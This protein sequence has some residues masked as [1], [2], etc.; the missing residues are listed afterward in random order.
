MPKNKADGAQKPRPPCPRGWRSA[1]PQERGAA[2]PQGKARQRGTERR[3]GR[4]SGAATAARQ[5]SGEREMGRDG[6][7]DGAAL[8]VR[9]RAET[10]GW[11]NPRT[12]S[13]RWRGCDRERGTATGEQGISYR[14]TWII[15]KP[16]PMETR[17]GLPEPR[18][19]GEGKNARSRGRAHRFSSREYRGNKR[20][21]SAPPLARKQ[22]CLSRKAFR[23]M[24]LG[25]VARE[26]PPEATS[27][28]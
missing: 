2:P 16:C 7:E 13:A 26:E 8:A 17:Q 12:G 21:T 28:T 1:R 14:P 9:R 11:G 3:Q 27:I 23:F 5:R 22:D 19:R 24:P 20:L 4:P 18:S 15:D 25:E 10:G 6:A